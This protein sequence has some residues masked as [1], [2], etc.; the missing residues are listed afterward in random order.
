M[1]REDNARNGMT[2][3]LNQPQNDLR[4]TSSQISANRSWLATPSPTPS[5]QRNSLPAYPPPDTQPPQSASPKQRPPVQPKPQTLQADPRFSINSADPDERNLADRFA[6]L[7]MNGG[8]VASQYQ[9]HPDRKDSRLSASSHPISMQAPAVRAGPAGDDGIRTAS[10]TDGNSRNS[11]SVDTNPFPRPPDPTYTPTRS[12]MQPPRN[13]RMTTSPIHDQPS[14]TGSINMHDSAQLNGYTESSETKT[15]GRR[16]SMYPPTETEIDAQLLFDYLRT[17]Q[18]LLVDVRSREEHDQGHIFAVSGIC[19]E[20]AA[21]RLN[22]S[23]EELQEALVLSPDSEIERYQRR[24]EFDLVVFYDQSTRSSDFMSSQD[25]PMNPAMRYLHDA[26]YEFNQEKPLQ[27]PPILLVGGLDAWVD[28]LG[29]GALETSSTV[30]PNKPTSGLM[31][32]P[33]S[34][35]SRSQKR[36]RRDYNPIDPEEERKWRE[37]ARSESIKLDIQPEIQQPPEYDEQPTDSPISTFAT[38]Y[39]DVAAVEQQYVE[40]N[41]PSRPAPDLARIPNYPA[42]PVPSRPQTFSSSPM[43]SVPSRPAPAMQRPSYGGVSER[44]PSQPIAPV[45][46]S[47]LTPYIPPKLK[48]LPRTGLH[49]FG[50]TCYMNATIQCLS[51]TIPLTAFFLDGAFQKY[52]QK[53]NWKGSKGLMPMLYHTLLRNL[54]QY[55]ADVDIIRPTNFR[56]CFRFVPIAT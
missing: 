28:L 38:R 22:M 40:S 10:L 48:R 42:P 50:V 37:R 53:E 9:D 26:L 3:T 2:S 15:K 46:P 45:K 5:S 19:I 18:V 27:R 44:M 6:K 30:T 8:H 47:Q 11:M 54:W 39:P 1:I 32:R 16:K 31:R 49:N 35:A 52:L 55:Q 24:N 12:S 25:E 56:V 20:P 51:A 41:P 4:P 43:S 7:R 14:T 13:V 34:S 17:F 36:S 33:A 23:A 29:P 21:L